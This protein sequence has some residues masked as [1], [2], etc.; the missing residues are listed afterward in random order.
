MNKKL[1]FV[2]LLFFLGT[3]KA[4][5]KATSERSFVTELFSSGKMVAPFIIFKSWEGMS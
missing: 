5:V 3:Y 2:L 4:E 1:L